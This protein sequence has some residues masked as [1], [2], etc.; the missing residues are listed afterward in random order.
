MSALNAFRRAQ[1][2]VQRANSDRRWIDAVERRHDP[3]TAAIA[4]T[5][6]APRPSDAEGQR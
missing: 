1:S 3:M 4:E 6:R 5:L 2:R